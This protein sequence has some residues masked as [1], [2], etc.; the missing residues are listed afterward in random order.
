M[1]IGGAWYP[2]EFSHC[3]VDDAHNFEDSHKMGSSLYRPP[4]AIFDIASFQH[5]FLSSP[6]P[7]WAWSSLWLLAFL[8]IVSSNWYPEG[9]ATLVVDPRSVGVE[10]VAMLGNEQGIREECGWPW[11]GG[12]CHQARWSRTQDVGWDWDRSSKWE[13]GTKMTKTLPSTSG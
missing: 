3:K 2:D 9:P 8:W 1:G 5:F 7:H 10:S 6:I 13:C 4:C 12:S 11:P